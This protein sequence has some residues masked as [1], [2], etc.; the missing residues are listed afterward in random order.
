MYCFTISQKCSFGHN[1]VLQNKKG[2]IRTCRH[3]FLY[4]SH[5]PLIFPITFT[6]P[7]GAWTN[8][9]D[10]SR[11]HNSI[12]SGQLLQVAGA[13]GSFNLGNSY[14]TVLY[15]IVLCCN[16]LYCTVLYCT[17]LYC[18]VLYC[19]VL[20]WYCSYPQSL[21]VKI[22]EGGGKKPH[23]VVYGS[24]TPPSSQPAVIC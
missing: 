10:H 20:Y 24:S 13:A 11:P 1:L 6:A 23:P 9:L 22:R 5:S 17:V 14:C 21:K 8:H 3:L 18:N 19:T 7:Y 4:S 2:F 12:V 15:C 16:V